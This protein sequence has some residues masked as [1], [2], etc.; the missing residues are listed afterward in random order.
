M[1]EEGVGRE[2]LA[3]ELARA[4]A[5]F[6]VEWGVVEEGDPLLRD[7]V[8]IWNTVG[9]ALALLYRDSL[10]YFGAS[11]L[12]RIFDYALGPVGFEVVKAYIERE[13]LK[14]LYRASQG[15]A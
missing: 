5:R 14:T 6:L 1:S 11:T 15:V 7:L 12:Q 8:E 2:K 10:P 4:Q 9:L 3:R 13:P